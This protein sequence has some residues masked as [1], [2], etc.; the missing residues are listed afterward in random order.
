[1]DSMSEAIGRR[2]SKRTRRQASGALR[3]CAALWLVLSIVYTPIHLCLEP[4]LDSAG[5]RPGAAAPVGDCV[6]D[7]GHDGDDHHE[8]HPAAQHKFKVTQPT[9]AL[10]AE[11]LPVEVTDWMGPG[12]GAPQPQVFGFSGLSPP[13]IPC[14]WQFLFRAALPVRA[15]SLLS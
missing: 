10:V 7:S 5:F 9:R 14:S 12:Q 1:M 3:L 2:W 13:E 4:H 11:M 15:P 6:E 8:R